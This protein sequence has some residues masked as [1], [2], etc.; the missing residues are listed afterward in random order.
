MRIEL[1][2]LVWKTSMIAIIPYLHYLERLRNFAI[3][4]TTW[5]AVILLLNYSRIGEPYR[6]LTC[7]IGF[8]DQYINALSTVR[9]G[10]DLIRTSDCI[11]MRDVFYQLNYITVFGRGT[12]TR[13][14]ILR[15]KVVGN[16]QLY[17][18]SM[19]GGSPKNRTRSFC[20]S[21]RRTH[22]LYQ[23]SITFNIYTK[24]RKPPIF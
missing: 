13:N 15:L 21:G 10:N 16:N 9:G 11:L 7:L 6:S 8:A 20:S 22:Q 1:I 12:G 23:R 4:S 5:Q 3:P 24:I 2:S 18:T 14:Q 17:Y 19:I